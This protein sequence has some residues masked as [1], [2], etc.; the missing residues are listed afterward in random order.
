VRIT[1]GYDQ[2]AGNRWDSCTS[3]AGQNNI[4]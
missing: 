2:P 4:V 3:S 1:K